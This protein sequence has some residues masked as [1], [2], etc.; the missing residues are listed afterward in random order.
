MTLNVTGFREHNQRT[1]PR[2][3][4]IAVT[5]PPVRT[6]GGPEYAFRLIIQMHVMMIVKPPHI[7]G[8]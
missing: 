5:L 2:L 8:A 6:I 1:E 4:S 3:N 7:S